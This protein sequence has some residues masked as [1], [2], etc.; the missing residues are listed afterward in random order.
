[1]KPPCELVQKDYLFQVRARLARELNS[2]GCSQT[3]IADTMHITQPAVSKY[4]SE[5]TTSHDDLLVD[6]LVIDIA[7]MI[8]SG[9]A[10]DAKLIKKVCEACMLS[11][12]GG[13][14]CE[15]HRKAVPSLKTLECDICSEL[16]SGQEEE[17]TGR[18]NLLSSM[19]KAIHLLE[20][21]R[22]FAK[23]IPQVRANLVTCNNAAK[24]TS[25]VLA[26]P[27]RITTVEGYARALMSP[28]FGTSKHTASLLLWVKSNWDKLR[29]C[30]C[31]AGSEDIISLAKG[32]G[33]E[34]ITLTRPT[35]KVEEII[36]N[37][38]EMKIKKP[39]EYVGINV[40]GGIGIEPI[41]YLF[42]YDVEE[43]AGRTLQIANKL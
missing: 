5:S 14:I 33:F 39:G 23:L 38:K 20:R 41:L 25:D 2:R 15:K 35:T 43:L 1:M 19:I 34:V 31:I 21:S 13:E 36:E 18:A 40:P 32:A 16:L 9:D 26:I 7:D 17:F 6:N 3:F 8:Q 22:T 10:D 30:I 4:L 28:R 27:G 42:G 12:I 37:L 11:R 24:S 29:S